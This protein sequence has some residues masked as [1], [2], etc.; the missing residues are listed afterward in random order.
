MRWFYLVSWRRP[1]QRGLLA[2]FS[3]VAGKDLHHHHFGTTLGAS[4]IHLM[5]IE[6]LSTKRT[7][8]SFAQPT[9]GSLVVLVLIAA[10]FLARGTPCWV[11]LFQ[12]NTWP[13]HDDPVD[14]SE[15]HVCYDTG[16]YIELLQVLLVLWFASP[17]LHWCHTCSIEEFFIANSPDRAQA[18][19]IPSW[20]FSELLPVILFLW[21]VG[22]AQHWCHATFMDD[23]SI[24]ND[25][26]LKQAS[27]IPIWD[28]RASLLSPLLSPFICAPFQDTLT[29]HQQALVT[30]KGFLLSNK[31]SIFWLTLGHSR[32][33][34]PDCIFLGPLFPIIVHNQLGSCCSKTVVQRTNCHSSDC[35]YLQMDTESCQTRASDSTELSLYVTMNSH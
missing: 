27:Y 12:R 20:I 31:R 13:S 28:P 26:E 9:F 11:N 33:L 21:I 32:G 1:E 8:S 10:C 19:H 16:F 4:F 2:W 18:R 35:G 3:G 6:H 22:S 23:F 25:A 29:R 15:H 17:A 30:V 7:G 14:V 24:T 34:L 5:L